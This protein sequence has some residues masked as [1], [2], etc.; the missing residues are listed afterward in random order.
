MFEAL[1]EVKCIANFSFALSILKALRAKIEANYGITNRIGR[2]F[3]SGFKGVLG[4][5]PSGGGKSTTL[6]TI[7][8]GLELHLYGHD[9]K[10]LGKWIPSG[11]STGVGLFELLVKYANSV[12]VIDELDAN[13]AL[14]INILKQ[15][16]SGMISRL[17]SRQVEPVPFTGVLL[18]ATNG[19][20]FKKALMDHLIAMLER[21]TVVYIDAHKNVD[22]TKVRV[23]GK[24]NWEIIRDALVSKCDYD[25]NEEELD[26]VKDLFGAKKRECLDP[27][28]PLFRQENDVHDIVLFIKRFCQVKNIIEYR[29]LVEV[30][31]KLVNDTVHCNPAK[32]FNFDPLER[33][34]YNFIDNSDSHYRHFVDICDQCRQAGV[35]TSER[36][37]MRILNK[38]VL[39]RLLNKYGDIYSTRILTEQER[40]SSL[41]GI[42]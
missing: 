39:A 30:I 2:S 42:L 20:S 19:I 7:F 5:G 37:V 1:E 41:S 12:I 32:F 14:H 29:V 15:I 31:E 40:Q 16:A 33:T 26:L 18:G 25:L 6:R 13:T 36:A 8:Y 4:I 28:K 24:I 35:F 38:M 22:L 11:I 23:G 27:A 34:I 10:P 17:R 9:G 21:F 3:Q